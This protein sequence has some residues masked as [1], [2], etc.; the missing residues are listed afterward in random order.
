MATGFTRCQ[1]IDGNTECD[2]WFPYIDGKIYCDLHAGKQ[3]VITISRTAKAATEE[4][5]S[6]LNQDME[7]CAA[8]TIPELVAHVQGIEEQIRGLERMRRAAGIV[9]REKESKLSEAERNALR[10]ESAGYSVPQ[11]EVHPSKRKSPEEKA[12]NRKEGFSAWAARLGVKTDE[13]MLMDDD[14]MAARI[15]KYKAQK[16]TS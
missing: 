11:R 9:K 4:G 8:M 15:A 7:F 1:F 2:T 3:E 12:K 6:L 13:L 14:E 5:I 16:S 10:A